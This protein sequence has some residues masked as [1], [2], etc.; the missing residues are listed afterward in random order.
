MRRAYR[1]TGQ[2]GSA[3]HHLAIAATMFRDMDMRSSLE[4][5]KAEMDE[6]SR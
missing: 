2:P 4:K 3:Q 6:G 1:A 5:A